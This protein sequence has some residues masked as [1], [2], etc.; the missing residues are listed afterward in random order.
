V[1]SRFESFLLGKLPLLSLNNIGGHDMRKE[2]DFS[3]SVR[4]PYIRKL[5]KAISIRIDPD[6]IGYFKTIAEETGIPYQNLM[7][8]YL[9]D[10]ASKGLR[11][12][13]SWQKK[14]VGARR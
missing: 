9:A 12:S 4:N 5:K 13:L 1:Q 7:N 2:Y 14:E 8:H 6:T 11:P 10:C 3:H